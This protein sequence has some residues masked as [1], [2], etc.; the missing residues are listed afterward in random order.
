MTAASAVFLSG[1]GAS[2]TE[3]MQSATISGDQ[4]AGAGLAAA[5]TNLTAPAASVSTGSIVPAASPAVAAVKS[6][7]SLTALTAPASPGTSAY[8]IG[9]VDV[10]E[11]SVFNVP[12]LS[13]T[14][15][16]ADTG[17]INLPLVGDVVA[18]GRTAQEIERDLT[19]KLGDKYL[20]SPQV[21]VFI[22]EYNSQRVTIEGAV[23]KPGVYPIRGKGTLLQ[24]VATAEGV[25]EMA[26]TDVLVFRDVAGKRAAAKFNLDEIRAGR[27]DDPPIQQ[28]D[29]IVVNNSAMKSAYQTLLKTLPGFGNFFAV[30][31]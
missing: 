27:A 20:Q 15:Q 12:D 5:S 2:L 22:K 30:L 24:Y 31:L 3:G 8:K 16:V 11:I 28:G 1:C 18:A 19:K 4:K 9:P 23:K 17:T 13:K 26:E 14:V 7:V 6:P 29:L 21:T 10:L 25:T